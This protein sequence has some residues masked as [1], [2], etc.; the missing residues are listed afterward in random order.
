[1]V[2]FCAVFGCTNRVKKD[3]GISFQRFPK[4]GSELE[5]QW[6]TAVRRENWPTFSNRL[7]TEHFNAICISTVFKTLT[8]TEL[9]RKSPSKWKL[10]EP[11]P[12]KLIRAVGYDHVYPSTVNVSETVVKLKKTSQGIKGKGMQK[13]NWIHNLKDLLS[14]LKQK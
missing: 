14:S 13:R 10:T 5:K 2:Q 7:C 9:K 4:K 12:S 6:I 1:M 11:S 3:S 8:K